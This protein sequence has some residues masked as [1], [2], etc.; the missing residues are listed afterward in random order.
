MSSAR[1]RIKLPD[2]V[3]DL[4]RSLHPHLKRKVRAAFRLILDDPLTGKAL[5]E[6]LEGLRSFRI[7]RFG[8]IY[9]I[10]KQKV[11]EIIAVG[12]RKTIYEETMKL[13]LKEKKQ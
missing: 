5:K 8:I 2:E 3:A 10:T 13:L 9:R 7:T 12:P 4:I 11:V 1:R 6:E